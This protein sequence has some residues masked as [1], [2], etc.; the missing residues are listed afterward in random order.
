MEPSR[1]R[2]AEYLP[3]AQT[4]TPYSRGKRRCRLRQRLEGLEAFFQESRLRYSQ[5]QTVSVNTALRVK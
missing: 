3:S 1:T 4:R 5:N 2:R